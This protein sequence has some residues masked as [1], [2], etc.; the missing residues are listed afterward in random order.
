M[1]DALFCYAGIHPR[2]LIRRAICKVLSE[3][4]VIVEHVTGGVHPNR[5]EQWWTDEMPAIGVYTLSETRIASD[6]RPEPQER[7]LSLVI[8]ILANAD[9]TLDDILD[10]LSLITEQSV[11]QLDTIGRAMGQIVDALLPEPLP[12]EHG[13][14]PADTLLKLTHEG[15]EIGVAVDGQ[16]QCGVASL[17]FSLEYAWPDPLPHLED[18][19]IANSG[20]FVEP[21]DGVMDM[22]SRVEFAPP[23]AA[24]NNEAA[25][26]MTQE[27][28]LGDSKG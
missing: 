10:H 24:H 17:Q 13:K 1:S 26:V 16:R 5:I 3:N 22:E 4:A 28:T 7:D 25:S 23:N 20:W 18:F 8:E 14:H 15:T 2:M 6:S 9:A 21:D 11:M 19:L 12:L 27:I